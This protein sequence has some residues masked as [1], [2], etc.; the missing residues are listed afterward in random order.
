[1]SDAHRCRRV[2]VMEGGIQPIRG[3]AA[4]DVAI[5][6]YHCADQ[7]PGLGLL[8]GIP[9]GDCEPEQAVDILIRPEDVIH[10]DESPVKAVVERR[11]FRGASVL[12]TLRLSSGDLVQALVPSH[13]DHMPGEQ[14]GI[15]TDVRHL[16]V[17]SKKL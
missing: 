1:M 17:F 14:I 15:R 11:N 9:T 12:Y 3:Q 2:T 10:D 8:D 6:L 5:H 16:V 7:V 4:G 13:C